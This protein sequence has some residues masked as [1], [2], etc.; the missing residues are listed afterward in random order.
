MPRTGGTQLQD[1]TTILKL[2]M[3]AKEDRR[4]YEKIK[5]DPT[6]RVVDQQWNST[7]KGVQW[8]TVEYVSSSVQTQSPNEDESSGGVSNNEES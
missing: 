6:C 4:T 3:D 8:M 7:P 5:N 2:C 1:R